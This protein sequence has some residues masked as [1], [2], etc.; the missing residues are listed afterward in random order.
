MPEKEDVEPTTPRIY[1]EFIKCESVYPLSEKDDSDAI[2]S[3]GEF[4]DANEIHVFNEDD[5]VINRIDNSRN[6]FYGL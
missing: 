3:D 4:A 6:M 1:E 5:S 2:S